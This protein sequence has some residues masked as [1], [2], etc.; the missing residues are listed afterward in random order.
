MTA[1]E[2]LRQR[3]VAA[4]RGDA[5]FDVIV[6]NGTLVDL[7]TGQLRLADIGIVGNR[8]ASVHPAGLRQDAVTVVDAAQRYLVPGLIDT[9]MHVESAMVMPSTYAAAV[10]PHGTTT[11]CWDPHELANVMGIDGVR[12]ALE[13]S[14]NL[15]LR[16][17]VMAPS[18]VPSAPGLERAGAN[19]GPDAVAEML[20]WPG[21]VGVAE[22][23]DMRGVIS[24][25]PR[26]AGI[27]AAGIASGKLV[28]GHARGLQGA[29]LQA[30]VAAGIGSDHEITSA[31]DLLEK[32]SAG[33]TIELRGSHDHLLPECV[34]AL[35]TLPHLP[36]TLTICTDDVF[37]DDL[38]E[39]GGLVD[40]LRRLIRYGLDPVDAIRCAT[41]HAATRLKLNDLGL[42]APGRTADILLVSDLLTL[43][44][45]RVI[46]GGVLVA[47]RG[48]LLATAINPSALPGNSM[49]LQPLSPMDFTLKFPDAPDGSARLKTIRGARFTAWGE[50][51]V[52]VSNGHVT[53]PPECAVMA[54]VHR[55][56]LAPAIPS[57][58]ALEDWG[59]WQGAFATTVAHDSH[60][61][62]VFGHD[63]RDMALAAN[64]L[65]AC[66]GGMAV[67]QDGRVTA[68]LPL[69]VCGLVSDKP[70][71]EIAAGFRAVREATNG[72]VDWRPPY[73]VFKAL[74]GA[75]LACNAGPHLT[76]MGISDGSTGTVIQLAEALVSER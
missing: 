73:R 10:V 20:G 51:P 30:F 35:K 29:Q 22:V 4:A 42:I 72:I 32:L 41:L 31:A 53:L 52:T 68:L 26:M 33:L 54:V 8:V 44:V 69:P 63:P 21:I 28:T 9:H 14:H 50:I 59:T 64:A 17:L 12:I 65:I 61:L 62:C 15:P 39:K 37:P 1:D 2:A 71:A 45:D 16:V 58:C 36:Q 75:S 11:V 5:P 27:V 46:A 56:G 67:A 57:L 55:H 66:G 3:A 23:M 60:N 13:A 48:Q 24:N 25:D 38:M 74:V 7:I 40:V 70:L 76:D 43:E 47:E 18:C 34:A 19:F 6:I 49:K